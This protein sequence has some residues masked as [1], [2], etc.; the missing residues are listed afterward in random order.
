MR[1]NRPGEMDPIGKIAKIYSFSGKWFGA[2]LKYACL[3]LWVLLCDFVCNM[4]GYNWIGFL[5]NINNFDA[6]NRKSLA[7]FP[8]AIFAIFTWRFR[9]RARQ[10]APL[11]YFFP[12]RRI[13]IGIAHLD[14]LD[15]RKYSEPEALP[16]R[17]Y[18]IREE[19]EPGF[20]PFICH[21]KTIKVF[22]RHF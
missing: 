15:D 16:T 19:I 18:F 7:Q 14:L 21:N 8:D 22:Y 17:T 12:P 20:M 6:R 5:F 9:V 13:F 4:N 11:F 2:R 3:M 10:R 1:K